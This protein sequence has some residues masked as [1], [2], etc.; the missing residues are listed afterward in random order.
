MK[1]P[2]LSKPK[3]GIIIAIL[4][5]ISVLVI[6]QLFF[7]VSEVVTQ[8]TMQVN[9]VLQ[10]SLDKKN[11]VISVTGIDED[12][13]ALLAQLTVQGMEIDQA[14]LETTNVLMDEGFLIPEN[15]IV[16]VLHS[17]DD[18]R[19][20]I[21]P[22]LETIVY[23][24]VVGRLAEL[25]LPINV[26]SYIIDSELYKVANE[27][28]MFP[29]DYADLLEANMSNEN[30]L[31]IF[32]FGKEF[33]IEETLFLEEFNTIT[34][35]MIDMTEA[36]I[37][38]TTIMEVMRITLQVDPSLEELSTITAG[39]ID[40]HEAGVA[41]EHSLTLYRELEVLGVTQEIFLEEFSTV[42]SEM[43]NMI[44]VGIT[45]A[46]AID[47]LRTAMQ[48]DPS[49]EELSTITAEAIDLKEA[50]V[51]EDEVLNRVKADTIKILDREQVEQERIQGE[52]IE[53]EIREREREGQPEQQEM[54]PQGELIEP[55][56]E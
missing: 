6:Y 28:G 56:E 40:M 55:G 20:D 21:L 26:V 1:L 2:K 29:D 39:M 17:V 50:G 48:V 33:G 3:W 11:R 31:S 23:Q 45:A 27:E 54:D 4:V 24:A 13:K 7:R 35:E 51:P 12:G 16:I 42:V 53:E 44:E 38:E 43:I 10:L 15:R 8:V 41:P 30:I 37:A 22:N 46:I 5:L 34:A 25:N 52:L 14:L 9:P 49:L 19:V 36:G 32:G 18:K 47:I